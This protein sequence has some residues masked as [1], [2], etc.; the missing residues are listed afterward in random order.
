MTFRI[1]L[2]LA[3]VALAACATPQTERVL[4][5][6]SELSP[7]VELSGVPFFPQAAYQCGPA[8][9][10]MTLAW[11]GVSVRARDLVGQV[12]SPVRQGSLPTEMTSAARRYGRVAYP[13]STLEGLLEEIAAG[14]PV[15]VL[16]DLGLPGFPRWHYAVAF[17]YDL[18]RE[19]IVLHS[20]TEPREV[21]TLRR[22]ERSWKPGGYWALVVLPPSK[23]PATAGEAVFLEAVV[24]LERA[25]RWDTAAQAYSAALARWPGSLGA[26]MGLGNSRYAMGDLARAGQAFREAAHRHPQSA[27]AFNNL[28]HV[29]AETGRLE[30]AEAA[31]RKAVALAGAEATVYRATLA[32]IMARKTSTSPE[33]RTF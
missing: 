25:R 4:K 19:D 21:M 10:A 24:G 14:N 30:E 27:P 9:L 11:S 16:Q 31:A 17:G 15:I 8:A 7:R 6:P 3:M 29:L 26:L 20:G 5:A 23:P 1:V 18:Q 32:E 28:A 2:V 12:Y 33:L 13:V 22:F